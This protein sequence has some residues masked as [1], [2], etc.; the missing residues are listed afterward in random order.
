MSIDEQIEVEFCVLAKKALSYIIVLDNQPRSTSYAQG[1]KI[2][3]RKLPDICNKMEECAQKAVSYKVLSS[4][5]TAMD[6][7]N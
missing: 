4:I 6:L 5:E 2:L 1:M 7:M 3:Y